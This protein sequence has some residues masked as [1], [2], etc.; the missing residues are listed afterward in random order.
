MSVK[1]KKVFPFLFESPIACSRDF[2]FRYFLHGFKLS[3]VC[4][5]NTQLIGNTFVVCFFKNI[6]NCEF[7]FSL[8]DNPTKVTRHIYFMADSC[9][10]N[11]ILYNVV[12]RWIKIKVWYSGMYSKFRVDLFVSNRNKI[13]LAVEIIL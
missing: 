10:I 2:L 4:N 9:L 13:Q 3:L 11:K 8:P 6:I 5:E 1:T 7:R 12:N